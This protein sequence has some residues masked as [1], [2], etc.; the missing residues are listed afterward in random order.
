MP[1]VWAGAWGRRD[2]V[3][4]GLG[5]V[6]PANLA[7]VDVGQGEVPVLGERVQ[8]NGL[9]VGDLVSTSPV[10]RHDERHDAAPGHL[11]DTSP[12]HDLI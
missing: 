2:G 4:D 12:P 9:S 10:L 3:D 6:G 11:P 1:P 7:G 5:E 8:T